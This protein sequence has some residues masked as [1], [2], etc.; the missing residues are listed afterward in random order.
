MLARGFDELSP[1][2]KLAVAY[3][4]PDLRA[5]WSLLLE[6]D[7]R[8]MAIALKGQEPLLKQMRYAW[9]REQM[10]RAAA[11]RPKGEPLLAKFSRLTDARQ[12]EA[13]ALTLIDAWEAFVADDGACETAMQKYAELRA[14]ALFAQYA[15]WVGSDV[16]A[17]AELGRVWA[18]ASL[19]SSIPPPTLKLS[20]SVKPLNL[21]LLAAAVDHSGGGL[22]RL[23]AMIRLYVHALTGV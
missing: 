9:W 1:P 6:F 10:N 17:A 12:V 23:H 22:A 15:R 8:M 14:D 21:L 19:S 3:A 13:A 16:A 20:R 11:D 4:R 5:S 18:L 2:E 7:H